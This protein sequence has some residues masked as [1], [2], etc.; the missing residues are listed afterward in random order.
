MSR[1]HGNDLLFALL[2]IF[3]TLSPPKTRID[4]DIKEKHE[5]LGVRKFLV[6]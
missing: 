6:Q 4:F 2:R 5:R 1:I 3:E